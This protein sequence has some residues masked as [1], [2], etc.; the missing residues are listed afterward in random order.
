[1]GNR[2]DRREFLKLT[3]RAAVAPYVFR[4]GETVFG[5]AGAQQRPPY[6]MVL[7]SDPLPNQ[8]I[9]VGKGLHP[10]RVVWAHD[11]AATNWQGLGQGHWW[12]SD[13]T[14]QK[15]V[16]GMMSGMIRGLGGEA[17]DSKA[18]DVL[19]KHFNQAHGKGKVGYRKGEKVTIKVNLVSCITSGSQNGVDPKSYD[20]VRNLDYMNTSPQMILALLRQFVHAAGV[21]Q[22]DISVGD[23]LCLFPNQYWDPLHREFPDV[24]YLDHDGGNANFPRTRVQYSSAPFYWSSR[25]PGVTR[26]YV[27]V[28]YVESKYLINMANMKSH[29]VA[30]V[31]LCAKNHIGSLIRKPSGKGYYD[32]HVSLPRAVPGSGHYRALVDVMGHAH[33]GGKT[34][35]YLV[36]GLYPGVHPTEHSPRKWLSAPFNGHWASSLLASQDP[37]AI[38]SVGFDFLRAEWNDYPHMSGADDYLHEAALADNP[39]SGAFYD[40]D[41]ATSTT[42]LASLGVHEH[43]N[44]A[45]DRQYS[46]NLGKAEGIELVRIGPTA[47]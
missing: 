40:P 9:G 11:P 21:P 36:D 37:V 31:T 32:V 46:R 10:G 23:P 14:S 17:S 12:E 8:P 30:G 42:R 47:A 7:A 20:L 13:R 44:N 29:A 39:P 25:P 41:H 33:T 19:I 2:W 5:I 15:A 24:H 6:Q 45:Q 26:D 16:D 34:L 27:P 22:R 18:W 28:S 38:D 43:W 1:M 3:G 35:L 4:A